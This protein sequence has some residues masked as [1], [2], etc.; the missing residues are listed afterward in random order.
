MP[1]KAKSASPP[2][3][4]RQADITRGSAAERGYTATWTR[5]AA[6]FRRQPENVMCAT[7]G[8]NAFSAQVD[9]I[10]ASTPEDESWLDPANHQAL[11]GPCH[12]AKT[13][14]FDGALGCAPDTSEA[15]Q[16]E[17]QRMLDAAAIRAAAIRARMI[18]QT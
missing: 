7:P 2:R 4:N 18:G 9:H 13:Q 8:C 16:A 15:G 11:C 17:L 6:S 12:R 10:I 14:R 1:F 5:Y 3:R